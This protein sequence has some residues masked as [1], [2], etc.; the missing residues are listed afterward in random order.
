[1]YLYFAALIGL[2]DYYLILK[3]LHVK[4]PPLFSILVL[5]LKLYNL[6]DFIRYRE[7]CFLLLMNLSGKKFT[8]KYYG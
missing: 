5:K 8:K 3:S 6:E 4:S 7:T 2:L 1:M